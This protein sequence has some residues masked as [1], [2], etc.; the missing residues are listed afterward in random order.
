ML[1]KNAQGAT[2][3]AGR[4]KYLVMTQTTTKFHGQA[5]FLAW[6]ALVAIQTA[7][8]SLERGINTQDVNTT[9][10]VDGSGSMT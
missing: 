3:V 8:T 1:A 6:P 2:R 5:K 4:A 7:P 10:R 9:N